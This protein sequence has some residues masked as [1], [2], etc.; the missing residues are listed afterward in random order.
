MWDTAASG[1]WPPEASERRCTARQTVSTAGHWPGG[2][3]LQAS[4]SGG[5][6]RPAGPASPLCLSPR[7]G[8]GLTAWLMHPNSPASHC[9]SWGKCLWGRAYHTGTSCSKCHGG[10]G[11][12]TRGLHRGTCTAPMDTSDLQC[13]GSPVSC[14]EWL[15]SPC[16]CS[17]ITQLCGPSDITLAIT[18]ASGAIARPTAKHPPPSATP[19][20][21]ASPSIPSAEDPVLMS[22]SRRAG[23]WP[24]GRRMRSKSRSQVE[25]AVRGPFRC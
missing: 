6:C 16:R 12:L 22:T 19:R 24:P 11:C 20:D 10:A 21:T 3:V 9:L 8:R 18:E 13:R 1:H 2:P 23:I 25:G 15:D 17:L 4:S 5:G 7:E 14:P